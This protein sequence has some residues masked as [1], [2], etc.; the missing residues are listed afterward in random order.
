LSAQEPTQHV[1]GFPRELENGVALAVGYQS[2]DMHE[3]RIPVSQQIKRQDRY[4]KQTE[5]RCRQGAPGLTYRQQYLA[6]PAADHVAVTRK[7]R[8]NA[9]VVAGFHAQPAAHCR[10]P[11][12]FDLPGDIGQRLEQCANLGFDERTDEQDQQ[13]QDKERDQEHGNDRQG[14]RHPEFL[15]TIRQ[16]I[17]H[18][19]EQRGRYER[20]QDR[21]QEIEQPACQSDCDKPVKAQIGLH[22]YLSARARFDQDQT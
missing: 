15:Q 6:A 13:S 22:V 2:A 8:T 21:R 19:R 3:K 17:S 10:Q 4:Q 12:L 9:N 1:V 7:K 11:Y 16:R 5:N 18:V 14:A 20:R